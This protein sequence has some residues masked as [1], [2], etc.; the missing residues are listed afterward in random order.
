MQRHINNPY[1][2]IFSGIMKAKESRVNGY[3]LNESRDRTSVNPASQGGGA[4][5]AL[6]IRD[7]LADPKATIAP[8][9]T[10]SRRSLTL[11]KFACS[12]AGNQPF[13]DRL[14]SGVGG[15]PGWRLQFLRRLQSQTQLGTPLLSSH[16]RFIGITRAEGLRPGT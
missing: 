8:W 6:G 11:A 9:R 15:A 5:A 4:I 16:P 1:P 12:I 2:P 7:Y 14:P 10:T 3:H 13:L